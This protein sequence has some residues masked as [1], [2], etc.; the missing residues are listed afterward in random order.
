M[1]HI[2]P[3]TTAGSPARAWA[4]LALVA[5]AAAALFGSFG[6]ARA[7]AD[8]AG[9]TAVSLDVVTPMPISAAGGSVDLIATVAA[10]DGTPI[11]PNGDCQGAMIT[12]EKYD[13]GWVPTGPSVAV[14]QVGSGPTAQAESIVTGFTSGSYPVEAVFQTNFAAGSPLQGSTSAP[15][16]VTVNNA[17]IVT[18]TTTLTATPPSLAAGSTTLTAAVQEVG[19]SAIP[20]G[21]VT[22]YDNGQVL[23]D[24]SLG[25]NG[26]ATFFATGFVAGTNILEAAYQGSGYV[27]PSSA[28]ITLS[29]PTGAPAFNTS[30][31]VTLN[32]SLIQA[33]GLVGIRVGVVQL[34]SAGAPTTVPPPGANSVAI[35]VNGDPLSSGDVNGAPVGSSGVVP[36]GTDGTVTIENVSDWAAG[37]TY[38]IQASYI[39][40]TYTVSGVTTI[41]VGSSGDALLGVYAPGSQFTPPFSYD[42]S[43]VTAV[44]GTA[45]VLGG[46]LLGP[47]GTPSASV[48]WVFAIG[49]PPGRRTR[50]PTRSPRAPS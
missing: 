12:F 49:V 31:T 4:R 15:Q 32:P 10:T 6:H 36:L 8:T 27:T 34:T 42:T 3:N 28:T 40:S 21:T 41:Y 16:Y 18:T 7:S 1:K 19:A 17:S 33:G 50:S 43:H 11:C 20:T 24:A 46:T 35:T 25:A 14:T 37:G 23:G 9:A 13:S 45:A 47:G 2:H 44:Y 29:G 22:F 48:T 39:G 30:T 26:V 38:D 5:L